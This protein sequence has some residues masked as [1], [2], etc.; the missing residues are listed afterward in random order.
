MDGDTGNDFQPDRVSTPEMLDRSLLS[1]GNNVRV[2]ALLHKAVNG[3]EVTLA[4]IGGSITE[5]FDLTAAG[6][7]VV[8]SSELFKSRFGS[9]NGEN[10]HAV[11][12]GMGGTPSTLGMI[13]YDRDVL[14]PAPTPPDLVFVEFAV[15]DGDDPTE[16]A[17]YE[18]LVRK[19]LL[20][21][22]HPAVV[23]VFSVFKSRW[24]LEDRLVPVGEHYQ[25]PM[26]SIKQAIVPELEAETMDDADFFR[27]DYHP[28]E[29]GFKIMAETID[30]YFE[31]VAHSK[32]DDKDI[33]IP[34]EPVIG[35]QFTDIAMIDPT[36]APDIDGVEIEPGSFTEVDNT[37]RKYGYSLSAPSTFPTNWYKNSADTNDPFTMTVTCKN[38]AFVYKQTTMSTFGTADIFLDGT[39]LQSLD[40]Q[41]SGGWN[42]PWTVI[43]LDEDKAASHTV[44]IKMADD[45]ADKSFTILAFGYTP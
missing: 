16:G 4:Y 31:T 34:D 20:S 12:A 22:N 38:L 35:D 9:G 29:Y 7:Y 2:K 28:T 23:L 41:A 8:G 30:Y 36:T 13:R 5:G 6:S 1:L 3:E 43:L 25:L 14:G 26:I 11:N 17:A 21:D 24:N 45:S 33:D 42:N 32:L 40:G 10:I 44:E 39:L 18:S 15:N 37:P 27:D 19:I